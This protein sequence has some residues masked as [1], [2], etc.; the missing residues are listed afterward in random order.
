[1]LLD[2]V[3]QKLLT[4]FFNF[5]IPGLGVLSLLVFLILVGFVGRYIIADPLKQFFKKVIE[6]IPLINFVYS[7]FNDY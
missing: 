7:V 3:S 2:G 4:K 1:M 5:E 6:R